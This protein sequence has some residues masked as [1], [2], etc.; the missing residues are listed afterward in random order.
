MAGGKW[1]GKGGRGGL[2]MMIMPSAK[3][4]AGP[5]RASAKRNTV[6]SRRISGSFREKR[7]YLCNYKSGEKFSRILNWR[8][9]R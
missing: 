4:A 5:P 2:G 3:R 7:Y 6:T 8:G 1:G 9:H